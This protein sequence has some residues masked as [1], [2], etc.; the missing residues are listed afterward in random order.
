M[1]LAGAL[2]SSRGRAVVLALLL[3]P[4]TA[5]QVIAPQPQGEPRLAID[6]SAL[7]SG[8]AT[9]RPG[10]LDLTYAVKRGT[11]RETLSIPGKVVP[12]RSAQLE[13]KNSGTV[14]A[15]HV[16]SGQSVKQGDVL[17]ELTLDDAALD[18]A[19]TRAVLADLA[20]ESQQAKVDQLRRGTSPDAL[21]AARAAVLKAQVEIQKTQ[22]SRSL[23][24]G[25]AATQDSPTAGA[26]VQSADRQLAIAR[27]SLQQAREDRDDAKAALARTQS[28]AQTSGSAAIRA[29]QRRLSEATIRLD[30]ARTEPAATRVRREIAGQEVRLQYAQQDL[31]E[32][33]DTADNLDRTK[34]PTGILGANALAAVKNLSRQV[35]DAR[36]RLVELRAD[37]ETAKVAD[38]Q[39]QQLAQLAVDQ[40]QDDLARAQATDPGD[41]E[42]AQARVRAAERKL[43]VETIQVQAAEASAALA[44]DTSLTDLDL[45]VKEA[46][47][48]L[49]QAKLADLQKGPAADELARE[50]KRAALL[51]DEADAARQGAQ[52]VALV[53]APFDGVVSS[54]DARVG[55]AVDGRAT[56]VRLAQVGGLSVMANASETEVTQIGAD[57]KVDV[58]FPGLGDAVA[59]GTI[60]DISGA[61]VAGSDKAAYPVLVELQGP[62]PTLK[63]GMSAL[64]TVSLR[65]AKDALYVPSNAVRKVEGKTVVTTVDAAGQVADAPVR[66]GA[67]YGSDVE[68]LGGLKEGDLV[69]IFTPG[70][71]AT[72]KKP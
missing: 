12:A 5:C 63:L 35:S 8:G 6:R 60:V 62:P 71:S 50:T 44:R 48:A 34:D 57:Q 45:Q 53:V 31:R 40:A 13:F 26:S 49:A 11:I 67:T 27:L 52:G 19:Q 30:Q 47:L 64:L 23:G 32:A 68:V 9:A 51:R 41:R 28:L 66:V 36:A 15:V 17:A 38:Q 69:A 55:Q 42:T 29:A 72:A 2:G 39:A 7:A 43:E 3:L 70:T 61:A 65:E 4:L 58:A 24:G 25:A 10:G 59:T 16:R 20:Y 18:A 37:L 54:V 1:Q 21:D 33:N 22:L 56:V 46:D 14:T